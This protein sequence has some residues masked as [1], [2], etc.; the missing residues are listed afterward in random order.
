MTAQLSFRRVLL[1][2]YIYIYIYI[3]IYMISEPYWSYIKTQKKFFFAVNFFYITFRR[4]F[5]QVF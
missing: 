2:G 5:T 4:H 1:P 3:Y